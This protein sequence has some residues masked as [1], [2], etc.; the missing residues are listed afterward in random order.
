MLRSKLMRTIAASLMILVAASVVAAQDSSPAM[1]RVWRDG[2]FVEVPVEAENS[3]ATTTTSD[4]SDFTSGS[5]SAWNAVAGGIGPM[6][7]SGTVKVRSGPGTYYYEVG[8]LAD[9]TVVNVLATEGG[10]SAIAPT[11]G[12]KAIV[13]REAVLAGENNEGEISAVGKTRVYALGQGTDKWAVIEQLKTG[14]KVKII[15]T[16]GEYY[17]IEMPAAAR[18]WIRSDLL[19]A[20]RSLADS[21]ANDNAEQLAGLPEIKP[22]PV[23]PQL[24]VYKKTAAALNEEMQ[25]P[26]EERNF[27]QLE[28]TLND[29]AE[30][31]ESSY[32][33]AAARDSLASIEHQR[34]LLEGRREVARQQAEME[35]KLA[36]IQRNAEQQ[37]N[38]AIR[39]AATAPIVAPDFSGILR[40]N[41]AESAYP[42]RLEDA[43][44][45]FVAMVRSDSLD[46]AEHNGHVVQLWGDKRY[47]PQ[48]KLH[49]LD[50]H[51]LQRA[52]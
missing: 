10:W 17:Q 8:K 33:K 40:K 14:D 41:L 20:D 47:L 51:R 36:E 39:Q 16:E 3:G 12:M 52:E 38:E 44:G 43:E 22:M 5:S 50:V 21:G 6:R 35:R 2:R 29:I 30:K 18:A 23:D 27:E 37:Q 9:A 28:A 4:S 7:V 49:G 34:S 15:S 42:Y 11:S 19:R 45:R 1:K 31:A 48:W 26:L 46:L 32:V 24:K 25:K 13:R